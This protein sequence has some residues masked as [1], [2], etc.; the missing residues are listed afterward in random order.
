MLRL[1]YDTLK[2]E[3]FVRYEPRRWPHAIALVAIIVAAF[4]L[5]GCS[6]ERPVTQVPVPVPCV[7]QSDVPPETPPLGT[8]P[9]DA[10]QAADALGAHA[11]RLRG[12]NRILRAILGACIR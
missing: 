6:R 8:I 10:R 3:L 1:G 5:A 4:A 7:N 9:N 12:E 11:L 2:D